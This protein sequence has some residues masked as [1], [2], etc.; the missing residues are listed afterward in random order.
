MSITRI[1]NLYVI[2]A[3]AL[4][5][6]RACNKSP[7]VTLGCMH[8]QAA[9]VQR[10]LANAALHTAPDSFFQP[11]STV[12]SAPLSFFA[13]KDLLQAAGITR[14]LVFVVVVEDD[15]DTFHL[16]RQLRDAS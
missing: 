3:G 2:L 5:I 12:N 16:S 13:S 14:P 1:A 9:A 8:E 4:T 6:L 7:S 11:R 10:R 15:I